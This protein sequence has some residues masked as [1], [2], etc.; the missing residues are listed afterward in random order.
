MMLFFLFEEKKPM[1]V[2]GSNAKIEILNKTSWISEGQFA[3][4]R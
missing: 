2:H 3:A 4:K 1:K